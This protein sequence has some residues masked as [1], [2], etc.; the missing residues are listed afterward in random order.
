MAPR[1]N[2]CR[3][4]SLCTKP[5]KH[6]YSRRRFDCN[7]SGLWR[8][9]DGQHRRNSKNTALGRSLGI[10]RSHPRGLDSANDQPIDHFTRFRRQ[11]STMSLYKN[12]KEI[13]KE[14]TE[15]EQQR[16][17]RKQNKYGSPACC[18]AYSACATITRNPALAYA[19][20]RYIRYDTKEE[21]NVETE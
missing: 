15:C 17:T 8:Q 19:R 1:Y 12:N 21:F 11:V 18:V 4:S 9:A 13:M 14:T 2:S 5:R 7:T 16:Q 3:A 10:A 6:L 20:V